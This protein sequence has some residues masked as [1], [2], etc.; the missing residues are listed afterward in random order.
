[1]YCSYCGKALLDDA[2]PAINS[3]VIANLDASARGREPSRHDG[4][5]RGLANTIGS[6]DAIAVS[7]PD[8]PVDAVKHAVVPVAHA[9]TVHLDDLLAKA[10]HRKALELKR[11]SERRVVLEERPRGLDAE[12]RLACARLCTVSEPV[13]LLSENVLPALL[14]HRGDAVPLDA[15]LDIG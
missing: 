6:E 13:E 15:L 4:Q 14:Y 5:E 9:N 8:E 12:A 3:T 1:M 11:V 2:M 10:R 7:W